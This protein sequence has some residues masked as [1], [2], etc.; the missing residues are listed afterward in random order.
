MID[1]GNNHPIGLSLNAMLT[2]CSILYIH[3]RVHL[4]VDLTNDT[5]LEPGRTFIDMVE[6]MQTQSGADGY[7]APCPQ[8]HGGMKMPTV[9]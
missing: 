8:L 5:S 9:F 1:W 6:R 2:L 3:S 4:T 7:L